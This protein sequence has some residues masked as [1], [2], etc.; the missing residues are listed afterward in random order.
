MKSLE[1]LV[2]TLQLA[3]DIAKGLPEKRAGMRQVQEKQ[4]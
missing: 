3:I 1:E 4:G 2:E